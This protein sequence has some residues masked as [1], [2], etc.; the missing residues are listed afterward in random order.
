[1]TTHLAMTTSRKTHCQFL[2]VL[3]TC[4]AFVCNAN[5]DGTTQAEKKI[6]DKKDKVT[7]IDTQGKAVKSV[8][9]RINY[10]KKQKPSPWSLGL[11]L[12]A[13]RYRTD[14]IEGASISS[15]RVLT[16]TKSTAWHNN[17][18][19]IGSRKFKTDCDFG[20]FAAAKI[21]S[22]D[23]TAGLRDVAFGL[24]YTFGRDLPFSVGAGVVNHRTRTF[25]AGL[26]E[27]DTLPAEYGDEI[28][29]HDRSEW[30]FLI[31]VSFDALPSLLSKKK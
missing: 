25:A 13:E 28:P 22:E 17:L 19:T 24:S 6:D 7:T 12:G 1:M 14:L 27:G 26:E 3:F 30:G 9:V 4:L 11:A 20:I 10:A 5:A 21:V 2:L 31:L 15:K 18:W 8:D 16:V 29:F 23:G